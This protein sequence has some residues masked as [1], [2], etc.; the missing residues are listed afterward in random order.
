MTRI[1]PVTGIEFLIL[2]MRRR[3]IPQHPLHPSPFMEM[4]ADEQTGADPPQM[5]AE[6]FASCRATIAGFITVVL[7]RGVCDNNV[8]IQG[9]F[10]PQLLGF[11]PCIAERPSPMGGRIG[12]SKHLERGLWSVGLSQTN[13]DRFMTQKLDGGIYLE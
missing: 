3:K 2:N 12:R 4:P 6:Y 13:D 1:D 11:L 7:R 8:S 5:S 10:A 9:N